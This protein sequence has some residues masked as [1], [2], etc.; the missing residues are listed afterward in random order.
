MKNP[1]N[2]QECLNILISSYERGGWEE[3]KNNS[4]DK[5][6]GM[7][8]HT[9]GRALRNDWKLWDENSDLHKWFKK[10]GIWHADDMSGIIL[11]SFHRK[12]NG[13]KID[14]EDQIKYYKDFWEKGQDEALFEVF[15]Q[16]D[17]QPESEKAPPQNELPP[18]CRE[19]MFVDINEQVRVTLFPEKN[20]QPAVDVIQ[21]DLKQIEGT[22]STVYMTPCETMEIVSGL[23]SAVQFYLYNQ[24][25]Y[26]KEVLEPRLQV[27]KDREKNEQIA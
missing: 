21:L 1:K 26:R 10:A 23:S 19:T 11:R 8:H 16:S 20:G 15:G 22:L 12:I 27:S 2:L 3:F 4:E 25:Q 14:L 18:I 24:E 5:A 13:K 9:T 6:I 17:S 7:C